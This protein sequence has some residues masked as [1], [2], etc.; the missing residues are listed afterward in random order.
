MRRTARERR[1]GRRHSQPAGE[2]DPLRGRRRTPRFGAPRWAGPRWARSCPGRRSSPPAGASSGA[3]TSCSVRPSWGSWIWLVTGGWQTAFR[4]ASTPVA[5]GHRHRRRSGHPAWVAVIVAGYRMLAAPALPRA[6]RPRASS[7]C[8]SSYRRGAARRLRACP[9]PAR[10]RRRRVRR[11]PRIGHRGGDPDPFGDQERVNVLLL[12]GDGGEGRDGV[13]TD[14]VIVASIATATGETTLFSLPR[15]LEDLP[16]RPT[17]R[18][19]SSTPTASTPQRE[20]EPAQR[21]VPQRPGG[22][23]GR[24][25][26]HRRP[27]ADF[28]KLGVGE[29]LGLDLDYFVLVN[30]D[31]SAGWSTPWAASR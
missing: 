30:L 26:P 1:S 20:R 6:A 15:N 12:G 11:G 23:P 31:G 28:L 19:P 22:A 14:T 13:R 25:G 27:G 7:S 16:S 10:P 5:A 18:W 29:A 2:A 9:R 24:P 17:A 21:R 4:L 3:F 8:C